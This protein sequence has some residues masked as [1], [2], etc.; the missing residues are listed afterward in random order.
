[1]QPSAFLLVLLR[2][3]SLCLIYVYVPVASASDACA[4]GSPE[5]R[6]ACLTRALCPV[7]AT[8]SDQVDCYRRITLQLLGATE[9]DDRGDQIERNDVELP[10]PAPSA[11]AASSTAPATSR[12]AATSP[13]AVGTEPPEEDLVEEFGLEWNERPAK[14]LD[15]IN[16]RIV[17]LETQV[18][19]NYLMVLDN[20]QVW[21]QNIK[22]RTRL[23][24]GDEVRIARASMRSF[25]LTPE[26]STPT[27]VSRIVCHG[28]APDPRC[29]R[30]EAA[31]ESRQAP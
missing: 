19:G 22:S 9:K 4:E 15:E 2:C 1:M 30:I 13:V 23:K 6:L 16:A 21:E 29:A 10:A 20:G 28:D 11:P 3:A 7:V 5:A 31:I 17:Y 25:K 14:V 24:E 26:R 18:R 12:T 27:N 8:E